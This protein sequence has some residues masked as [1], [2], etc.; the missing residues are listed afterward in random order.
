MVCFFRAAAK[1]VQEK[2]LLNLDTWTI[3]TTGKQVIRA[4]DLAMLL[5]DE[6]PASH[7]DAVRM[8]VKKWIMRTSLIITLIL[9][10]V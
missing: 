3:D 5:V 1:L 4:K 2:T 7:R 9:Y 10:K 8:V 6:L